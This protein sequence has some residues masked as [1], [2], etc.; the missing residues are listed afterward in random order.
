MLLLRNVETYLSMALLRV[1]SRP[2]GH[3][4]M[5]TLSTLPFV[6]GLCEVPVNSI[7]RGI[8]CLLQVFLGEYYRTRVVFSNGDVR[9]YP[10]GTSLVYTKLPSYSRGNAVRS[11][12]ESIQ[13]RRI[14][15]GFRFVPGSRAVQTNAGEVVGEGTSQFSLVC[16][17]AAIEAKRALTR[18]ISVSVRDVCRRGTLYRVRRYLGKV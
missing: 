6:M 11:A 17:S 5:G 1:S 18:V 9:S 3:R 8:L 2:Q 12:R 15:V 14:G 16:A 13:S 10:K 4:V 7:S